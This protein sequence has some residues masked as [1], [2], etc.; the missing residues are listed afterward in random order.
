MGFCLFN[1]VAIGARY[2][3]KAHG[4]RRVAI[5]DWDV[6]HGNGS[7]DAFYDGS[8]GAFPVHAPVP[9]LSRDRGR[10]RGGERAR[11]KDIP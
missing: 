11:E 2:L 4:A 10:A 9:L 6:H 1:T 8:L 5:M 7:Q 3:Q